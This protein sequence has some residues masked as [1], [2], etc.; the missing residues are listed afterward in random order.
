M[1]VAS[2]ASGCVGDLANGS[3]P[4]EGV[5]FE[6]TAFGG[7]ADSHEHIVARI[8]KAYGSAA[9]I[10]SH[11]RTV[12]SV[13]GLRRLGSGSGTGLRPS[14]RTGHGSGVQ[15]AVRIE[16][17]GG[18]IKRTRSRIVVLVHEGASETILIAGIGHLRIAVVECQV[19]RNFPRA[20]VLRA[21]LI[22]KGCL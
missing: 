17:K 12:K 13:I 11:K 3:E 18:G 10:G 5:E 9:A 1:L 7:R 20:A 16:S 6:L 22:V 19:R 2:T 21:R 14:N 4:A 15:P 8:N